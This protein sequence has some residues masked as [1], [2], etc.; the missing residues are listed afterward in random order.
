M[1]AFHKKLLI[2][3][4][5]G[6][7]WCVNLSNLQIISQY[8]TLSFT[9]LLI[10][11]LIVRTKIAH[12]LPIFSWD[13]KFINESYCLAKVYANSTPCSSVYKAMFY[14]YITLQK[15]CRVFNLFLQL[16][17][18]PRLDGIYLCFLNQSKCRLRIE[19]EVFSSSFSAK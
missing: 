1:C 12:T 11:L 15:S 18:V 19:V 4:I 3:D 13:T 8:G 16:L 2:I 9:K 6:K 7:N 10:F 17:S 14:G 5:S